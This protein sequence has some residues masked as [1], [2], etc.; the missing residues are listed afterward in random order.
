MACEL[1]YFLQRN[2]YR[3]YIEQNVEADDISAWEK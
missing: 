2:A 3:L 1:L